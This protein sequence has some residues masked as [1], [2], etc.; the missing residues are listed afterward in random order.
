MEIIGK[1]DKYHVLCDVKRCGIVLKN[2]RTRQILRRAWCQRI[3]H[4]IKLG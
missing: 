3:I 1:Q 2:K 4:R